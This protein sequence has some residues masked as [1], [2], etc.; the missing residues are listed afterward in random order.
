MRTPRCAQRERA[1][2]TTRNRRTNARLLCKRGRYGM[3]A[4][5]SSEQG[6]WEEL[7]VVVTGVLARQAGGHW[8]EPV[9]PILEEP[10]AMRVFH[11][12]ASSRAT[13]VPN[14][15]ERDASHEHPMSRGY[16]PHFRSMRRGTSRN[17]R[18]SLLLPATLRRAGPAP[19]CSSMT[20]IARSFASSR[21]V[22]ASVRPC[23]VRKRDPVRGA[24]LKRTNL[25]AEL[26]LRTLHA[27]RNVDGTAL[28]V[29]TGRRMLVLDE[30][31]IAG[32]G[33]S[34]PVARRGG[35]FT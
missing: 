21:C 9:P 11:N 30:V 20:S 31:R 19:A 33:P 28:E 23:G 35:G 26:S 3:S 18:A 8:F 34:L 4:E 16:A 25:P 2:R 6:K 10:A 15:H 1:S 27:S 12:D 7:D 24:A 32:G 29:P 14:A 17:V 22:Y 5:S 13:L